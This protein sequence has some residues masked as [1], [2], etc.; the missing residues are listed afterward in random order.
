M[1]D[2]LG[3]SWVFF[4]GSAFVTAASAILFVYQLAIVDTLQIWV[5]GT[6]LLESAMFMI[7]SAYFVAGSY[8]E[9]GEDGGD[10]ATNSLPDAATDSP[11]LASSSLERRLL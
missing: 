8:P 3:G 6:S 4:W 7:G 9:S 2:W 1:N 11:M 10:R 5:M